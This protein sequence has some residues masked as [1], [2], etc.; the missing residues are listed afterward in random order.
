[1]GGLAAGAGTQW[2]Q[3]GLERPPLMGHEKEGRAP[4]FTPE[5]GAGRALTCAL[6]PHGPQWWLV[7]LVLPASL[8]CALGQPGFS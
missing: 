2:P 8:L 7:S 6:S 1:M 5:A 3:K 4:D